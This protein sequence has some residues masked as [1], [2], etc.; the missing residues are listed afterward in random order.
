MNFIRQTEKEDIYQCPTCESIVRVPRGS[1][2]PLCDTDHE[3]KFYDG[4]FDED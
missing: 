1:D 4:M 2:E 3:L